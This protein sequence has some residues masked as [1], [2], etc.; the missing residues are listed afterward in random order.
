MV[1]I[2]GGEGHNFL[3]DWWCLPRWYVQEVEGQQEAGGLL[4]GCDAGLSWLPQA[5]PTYM[6]TSYSVVSCK[7]KRLLGVG[8]LYEVCQP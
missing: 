5:A 3:R 6:D 4:L 7:G 2:A 8:N 1:G